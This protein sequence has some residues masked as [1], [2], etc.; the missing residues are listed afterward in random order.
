M[1]RP[2]LREHINEPSPATLAALM[3][4]GHACVGGLIF[5][6]AV[7]YIL[8]DHSVG[9]YLYLLSMH[10]VGGHFG[11]MTFGVQDNYPGWFLLTMSCL[12]DFAQMFYVYT[13]YVRYGYRR[14][15]RW[16]VV[17][18]WVKRTHE[19]AMDH[20]KKIAPYGAIGLFTFVVLPSPGSG[21]V[22]GSLIGYT[23]G[24]GSV[25]TLVS[26]GAPIILLGAL[27]LF[28]VD[29][30][31]E[32]NAKAPTFMV[33]GILAVMAISGLIAAWR[34]GLDVWRRGSGAFEAA[35]DSDDGDDDSD[36]DE[37]G[38]DDDRS[39]AS[40]PSPAA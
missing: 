36:D 21:P 28:G 22:M 5:L 4:A 34:F 26:C 9:S 38:D 33:Y 14:L 1:R 23:L 16:R 37:G 32:W 29:R 7:S 12:Q 25:V 13:L 39:P 40:P 30:A 24:L 17:G 8:L 15:L 10:M 6:F 18:P 11:T 3:A 31:A 2:R 20:H 35:D 19:A 27:Y